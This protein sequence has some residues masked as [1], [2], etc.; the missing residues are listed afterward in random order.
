MREHQVINQKTGETAVDSILKGLKSTDREGK[1]GN[2]INDKDNASFSNV[3]TTI[4]G[5]EVD[6]DD[7]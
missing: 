1:D 4:Y 3:N 2:L 7:L 6:V 5:E